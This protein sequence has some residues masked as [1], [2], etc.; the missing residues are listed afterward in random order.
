[1]FHYVHH[2]LIYNSQKL[3]SSQMPFNR[4]MDTENVVHLHNGILLSYQKQWLYEIHT[5]L[6]GT[7]KCHPEWGNPVTEKHTW[8]ALTDKWILAQKL[9]MS[10]IQF[11]EH[12][13]LTK[14]DQNVNASVLLSRGNKIF[15]GGNTGTNN[16][17]ETQGKAIQRLPYLG[18]HAI[19]SH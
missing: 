9:R 12:M 2:S 11:T 19:C 3:E 1:M 17:A 14:E 6:D 4:G 15:R 16:R 5:Q 13:K 7:G 18:T 10:K 8:Y